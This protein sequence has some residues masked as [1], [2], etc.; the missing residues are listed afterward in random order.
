MA[1]TLAARSL[2]VNPSG[3]GARARTAA[4]AARVRVLLRSTPPTRVTPIREGAG[5]SSRV[6]S[7]MNPAST[8]SSVVVHRSIMPA[9]RVTMVGNLSRVRPQPSCL[10][11]CATASKRSTRSPY[12]IRGPPARV[13]ADGFAGVW[14]LA[15]GRVCPV[16]LL[17]PDRCQGSASGWSGSRVGPWADREATRSALEA[18]AREWRLVRQGGREGVCTSGVQWWVPVL[19]VRGRGVSLPPSG[20]LYVTRGSCAKGVVRGAQPYLGARAVW[21]W[22]GDMMIDRVSPRGDAA[23]SFFEGRPRRG[24][25]TGELREAGRGRIRCRWA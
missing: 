20:V 1:W 11:L 21:C 6:W 12:L 22:P 15:G 19:G 5:R 16:L 9:R 8:Q 10:V 25:A 3:A 7:G 13:G 17:A 23:A 14:F 24:V 18:A 4:R 2:T